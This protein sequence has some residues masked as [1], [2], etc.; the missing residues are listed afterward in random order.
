[1]RKLITLFTFFI[2]FSVNAQNSKEIINISYSPSRI[3]SI[4]IETGELNYET[5]LEGIISS[6]KINEKENIIYVFSLPN[7]YIIDRVTGNIKKTFNMM[8]YTGE[9]E[10][11]LVG[12]YLSL[13]DDGTGYMY[14]PKGYILKYNILKE[15]IKIIGNTKDDSDSLVVKKQSNNT[16]NNIVLHNCNKQYYLTVICPKTLPMPVAEDKGECPRNK[17][18][19]KVW[20]ENAARINKEYSIKMKAWSET[21]KNKD[22]CDYFIY[23]DEAKTKQI[24]SLEGV[25]KHVEIYY[26]KYVFFSNGLEKVMYNIET[27]E[28]LWTIGL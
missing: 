19:Q 27:G 28:E 21:I 10:L 18:S 11:P 24:I 14:Q 20:E 4:N 22:I 15:E 16:S 6:Y 7:T 9:E 17:K 25:S 1:M 12:Y 2:V 26:D 23:S 13:E 5:D 3:S 8:N